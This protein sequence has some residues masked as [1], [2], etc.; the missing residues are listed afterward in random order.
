MANMEK[1]TERSIGWRSRMVFAVLSLVIAVSIV[2]IDYVTGDKIEVAL[3]YLVPIFL[4]V[5]FS[6][7]CI[8]LSI[9]I[10]SGFIDELINFVVR[11]PYSI[12]DMWNATIKIVFYLIFVYVLA[13]LKETLDQERLLSRSDP[14]TG[15]INSRYFYEIGDA[16]IQRALRYKRPFSIAYMDIDNFKSF[17]D[18]LGHHAGDALLC[19][20]AEKVKKMIRRTDAFARLG[21]DEFAILFPETSADSLRSVI[22]R[23]QNALIGMTMPNTVPVTFSIGAVSNTGHPCSIDELIKTADGLMYSAKHSGKNKVKAE[24][25]SGR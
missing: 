19:A 11:Q 15:L 14:L 4:A 25:L 7:K 18:S 8:A 2:I 3:F 22:A 23:I 6:W 10:G 1:K 24:T 12:V 9:A 21:G 5:W 17:N 20:I 16:E 13:A